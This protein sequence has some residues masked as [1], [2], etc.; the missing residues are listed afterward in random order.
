ME[1]TLVVGDWS[2]D[3][4]EMMTSFTFE[5]NARNKQHVQSSF[6]LGV[7]LL[8]YDITESCGEYEDNRISDEFKERLSE[9]YP[10]W[11]IDYSES[12]GM[13]PR[14]FAEIYMFTVNLGDIEI[15]YSMC[16]SRNTIGIGGYG[17]FGY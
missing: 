9:I 3:G 14:L 7:K 15:A 12:E 11:K 5:T 1:I 6:R 13:Y 8:G 16:E 2:L 4:H 17:L 10:L